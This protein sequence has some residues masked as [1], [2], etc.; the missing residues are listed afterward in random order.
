MTERWISKL[1]LYPDS[2][3]PSLEK[4][5]ISDE[6]MVTDSHLCSALSTFGKYAGAASAL[7]KR[8]RKSRELASKRLQLKGTGRIGVQPTSTSRRQANIHM[9]RGARRL[10]AGRPPKA[11]YVH[12]NVVESQSSSSQLPKRVFSVPKRRRIPTAHNLSGSVTQNKSL[13]KTHSSK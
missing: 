11:S 9:G 12:E 1:E 5:V 2:F 7:Q 10:H 3:R 6:K 4:M 13:G 8:G